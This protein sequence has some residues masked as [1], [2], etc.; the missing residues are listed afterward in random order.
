MKDLI[1]YKKYL[2]LSIHFY[3]PLFKY[4]ESIN[5]TINKKINEARKTTIKLCPIFIRKYF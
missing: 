4:N 3:K 1:I 5:K 2:P